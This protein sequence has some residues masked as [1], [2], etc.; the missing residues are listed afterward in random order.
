MTEAW[1]RKVG[2]GLTGR[3]AS[4][5][6]VVYTGGY[7]R[8]VVAV[9]LETGA[10]RWTRRLPG[11]I[12]AGLIRHGGALYVGTDRPDDKVYALDAATGQR[13]WRRQVGGAGPLALV[14]GL[15]MVTSRRGEAFGLDPRTGAIRWRQRVGV[16]RSPAVAAD[17]G[18]LLLAT[19][20][21]LFLIRSRDGE[22]LARARAPSPVVSDWVPLGGELVAGTGDSTVIAVDGRTLAITWRARLDAPVFA[23]PVVRGDTLIAVTRVGGI[24]RFRRGVPEPPERL[25]RLGW[26]VTTSP[27]PFGDLLLVGGADGGIRAVRSDGTEAWRMALSPPIEIPPLPLP[28]GLVGFGGR[29]ELRRY[30][31]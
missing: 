19:I 3:V 14:H 21:S 15:V 6:G 27:T 22:I 18:T 7:D 9:S 23:T 11:P 1:S 30:R 29:G 5:D 31:L 24:W 13:L 12:S 26:P 2:R 17:S 10:V 8:R 28:D 25:A 20:D 16:S 4:G